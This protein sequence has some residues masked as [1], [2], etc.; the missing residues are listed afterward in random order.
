V[1]VAPDPGGGWFALVDGVVDDAADGWADA[2]AEALGP[3]GT[4][5]WMV[6]LGPGE[7]A[8]RVPAA[9]GTTRVAAEAFV[10]AVRRRV[11]GATL[12]RAGTPRATELVLEAARQA[13]D[14]LDRS[15]RW[16]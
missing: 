1:V 12:V 8:W 13:P 6:D 3:L 9:V 5:R 15:L 4:P 11:P 10:G 14:H 7:T 2:V 16:R